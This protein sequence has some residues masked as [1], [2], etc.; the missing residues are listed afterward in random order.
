MVRN[1]GHAARRGTAGIAPVAIAYERPSR[2]SR[3]LVFVSALVV[4]VIAAWVLTPIV[5]T[6]YPTAIAAIPLLRDVV[7]DNGA[8]VPPSQPTPAIERAPQEARDLVIDRPVERA[9]PQKTAETPEPGPAAQPPENQP[10]PT[11]AAARA[12]PAP[13]PATEPV[14]STTPPGLLPWPTAEAPISAPGEVEAV[15]ESTA[16]PAGLGRVPMPPRRP[17][18]AALARLGIPMPRPR[19][20]E[21]PAAV[22]GDAVPDAERRQFDRLSAP[23]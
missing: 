11:L 13:A 12:E 3:V 19:P 5:L 18:A 22:E 1:T 2:A 20:N 17:D 4:L 16:A 6:R 7:A 9:E 21:A 23:N 8:A 15:E 10:A 14:T